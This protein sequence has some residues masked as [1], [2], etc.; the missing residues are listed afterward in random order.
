MVETQEF[1]LLGKFQV[2]RAWDGTPTTLKPNDNVNMP[3]SITGSMVIVAQNTSGQNSTGQLTIV[4]GGTIYSSPTLYGNVNQPTVIANN[5]DGN[6]LSLTN[7]SLPG[8]N[9][10]I[11]ISTVGP[12][13]GGLK[14]AALPMDGKTITLATGQSAQ[15]NAIPTFMQL[16]LQST[17]GTLTVVALI[18]GPP[19]DAGNTAK[20]IT[21][22]DQTNSGPGTQTA[23]PA[24]YYATTRSN[25][26]LLTF[27]WGSSLV[28]VAN[29]SPLTAADL[30]VGVRR[31]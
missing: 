7:T 11:W 6:N 2:N 9:N 17:S 31:L 19:D 28:F 10:P 29:E 22:N 4:S 27:N 16:I 20:V 15:A 1:E 8:S 24:G 25:T 14:P 3:Q 23:P 18:G 5:W 13:L 26:Y 30:T 21:L 12:G